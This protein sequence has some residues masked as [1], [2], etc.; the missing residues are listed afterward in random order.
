MY[1]NLLL[2]EAWSLKIRLITKTH[3]QNMNF[4]LQIVKQHAA[5]Y[6]PI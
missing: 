1:R 2:T 5:I 3:L 4:I 6:S